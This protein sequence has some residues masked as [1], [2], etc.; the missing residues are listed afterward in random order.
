MVRC[1]S[2][3]SVLFV[4]EYL[5]LFYTILAV[6]MTTQLL[7]HDWRP[8][9]VVSA[10]GWPPT[11][12]SWTQ[13]RLNYCGLSSALKLGL[14]AKVQFGTE[15]VS[16]SDHVRVLGVTFSSDL[17]GQARCQCL[18]IELSSAAP[19]T[20][21]QTIP[22]LG[23]HKCARPCLHCISRGL[24]QCCSSRITRVHDWQATTSDERCGTSRH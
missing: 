12:S 3:F 7:S 14:A 10:T 22:R 19:V 17:S 8:A 4:C 23:L 18:L 20:T 2:D 13:R 11:G 1:F 24:L 15:T 5:T 21:C 6:T 16:A 9:S